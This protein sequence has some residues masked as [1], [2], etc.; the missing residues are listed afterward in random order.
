M[1]LILTLLIHL[2]LLQVMWPLVVLLTLNVITL[3]CWTAIA[4]L[5][6]VRTLEAGTDPWNRSIGSYGQCRST[7]GKSLKL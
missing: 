2:P 6:Y 4:P 7:S 3:I 5:R 1:S